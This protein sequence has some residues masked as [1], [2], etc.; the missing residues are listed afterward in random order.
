MSPLMLFSFVIGYFVI[1]LFVANLT[2]RNSNN[3]SFFIGNRSSNWMLVA[4]GMIGTSLSGVT[5]VSVPGNVGK[6]S[7]A[8]LQITIGYLI[9][10]ATIAFVLLPLYYRLNVTSIYH[11]LSTRF[12]FR[13]YKTGSAFFILSRTLG[14]TA[15]LFLVVEILQFSILESFHVPFWLTTV[16]IL[17]MILL[18]TYKGGVKTIVWTDTLQTTC[19]LAGLIIC[20]IFILNKMG[21]S[22]TDSLGQ[23]RE[24]GY[25]KIFFTDVNSKLFFV[26][27][28]LAGAFITITMTGMDQEMMQKNLSVRTLG[29]SKKNVLTMSFI[30]AIVLL[31]FLFLGGLLY[32]YASQQGV[33]VTGDKLFPEI[34][35]H[36]M[37]PLISVIFIIALISA[38]F[39]SADGAITALTSSFCIDI[40]GLKRRDD[41]DEAKKKKIR[42]RI[43]LT[44]AFIFLVFVMIFKWVNDQSMINVILKVA[45]YTYGPLLGL[46]SFGILT[47]RKVIDKFVPVVC[48]LAP[49]ICFFLDKFQK[50]IFGKYEIGLELLIINGLLTFIGLLIISKKQDVPVEVKSILNDGTHQ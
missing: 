19:M 4:F 1:L 46:F 22:F 31:L 49:V 2:S 50:D 42:Q 29:N 18:Y 5:F 15:R 48:V 25:S 16:I 8:Y 24:K 36:H 39:P 21:L 6:E 23:M 44:V 11:Y 33:T 35:L 30:L 32:L 43:H 12:G 20:V 28:I 17:V 41:W 14:A 34:A 26:K 10:Y 47:K 13:S 37:P 45:A 3:E 9:G 40:L 7:F 27:Q 38:L